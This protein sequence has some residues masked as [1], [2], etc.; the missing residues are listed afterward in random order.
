MAGVE[1]AER[2][3][4]GVRREHGYVCGWGEGVGVEDPEAVGGVEPQSA[5]RGVV[6][7]DAVTE[8]RD[9]AAIDDV[10]RRIRGVQVVPH[11]VARPA[12]GCAH[13]DTPSGPGAR[14]PVD[15]GAGEADRWS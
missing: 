3:D 12:W 6:T 15:G 4:E 14:R 2:T 11:G 7:D 9:R 13:A 1:E 10:R 5:V 8:P